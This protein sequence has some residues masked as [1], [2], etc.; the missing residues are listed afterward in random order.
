MSAIE[1]REERPADIQRIRELNLL[2]FG[3]PEEADIVDRLRHNCG[4]ILSMVALKDNT[5][6]GHLL[7]SPI[8]IE[9]DSG[10]LQGMALGPMAVLPEFQ[11]QGVGSELM[12]TGISQMKKRGC[13]FLILIGH[14]EY[15]PR[16]GFLPARG[17]GIECE[18]EVPD[19]AFMMLVLDEATMN[20]V[21]GTAKYRPEFSGGV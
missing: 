20:G 19:E 8:V 10:A 5:V 12:T 9:G 6:V 21:T 17:L 18:W 11:R 3:Q 4:D 7:F 15:Y 16:F 13:P 14:P 1:V 2:A